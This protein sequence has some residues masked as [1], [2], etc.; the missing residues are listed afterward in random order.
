MAGGSDEAVSMALSYK[1]PI[2][3]RLKEPPP[4]V[5]ARLPKPSEFNEQIGVDLFVLGDVH[6]V[7]I[8]FLNTLCL[9]STFQVVCEVESKRPDHILDTSTEEVNST[10]SSVKNSPTSASR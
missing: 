5:P 8:S 6:G 2:C 9:S 4:T 10:R 1:C 3:T 7:A